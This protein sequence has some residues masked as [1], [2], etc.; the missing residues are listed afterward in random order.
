LKRASPRKD[1]TRHDTLAAKLEGSLVGS[2]RSDCHDRFF[3]ELFM[4]PS[5]A[6][7]NPFPP[8]SGC[9]PTNQDRDFLKQNGCS[10]AAAVRHGKL[11]R[12][13]LSVQGPAFLE[14]TY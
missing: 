3:H 1:L 7:A 5:V 6:M 2:G 4:S 8:L 14:V 11:R 9:V 12:Q 13:F 10:Q